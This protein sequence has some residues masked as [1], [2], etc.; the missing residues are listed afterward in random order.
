MRAIVF[1]ILAPILVLVA[2]GAL[3]RW[4]FRID[5]ASLGKLNIYLF[6]PAFVFDK[7]SNST[8][9]WAKMG[10]IVGVSILQVATLGAIVWG[11]GR[12]LRVG[13]K[14]LAAVAISVMFYNSGNYGLPLA[15]LAYNDR[16]AE[17]QAFVLMTQNVLTFT[18]GLSIA[19]MAHHGGVG[20][21]LLMLLRLPVLYTLAA[22]LL[23]R[24]YLNGHPDR[25]LPR[26]ISETARFL[27]DGLVPVAL[28]TLGAQLASS[29]RWPRWRPISLVLVM[30]LLLGPM[31]MA[32]LLWGLHLLAGRFGGLWRTMDLWPW[33]AELL[34]LTASVP[35]AVNTLLLTLELGGDAE[36]AADCVFWTTVCSGVSIAAWLVMIRA[37]FGT[38]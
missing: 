7:V 24:V 3:M 12:T 21:G 17:V 10:G 16:G 28:V 15:K 32:G 14:T 26:V 27:A 5:V 2:L 33:P 18:V 20:K 38:G 25:Q 29:P 4:R 11:M 30:R 13:R 23:A 22:A 34:I 9:D 1:D 37:F 8:L 35:T 31:Q 36:L 6:V 19:A